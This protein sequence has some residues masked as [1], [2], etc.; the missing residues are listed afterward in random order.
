MLVEFPSVAE[1]V[2]L[3][4]RDPA[5]HGAGATRDVPRGALDPVPHRHQPRRR[6]RRGR[7]HLRRRRQRRRAAGDAGRAGRH[8]RL[9]GGPRPGRR[10]ARGRAS[11]TWASSTVKNIARPIR[12]FRVAARRQARAGATAA[13]G[14]R[15]PQRRADKPSIAVL[16]FVNMSGD[17]EQEFFAD[18]LT[19]DIIT[20]LSRFRELLV[21]SRNSAFVHKGKPVKVQEVA[22][23][24]GVEYV[25]E[26]S[27]RKAGRPGAGHRPADR[28]RDRPPRLGRALRPRAR[29]HLR[30]PGRGDRRDRRHPA[31]PRR[32]GDATT[33]PSA[34]RPTAWRPTSACWPARCCTIARTARTTPRRCACS[35][36]RIA[37]DPDYAHAHA[38][39]ACVLGQTWVNGWCEDRDADLEPRGRGAADGARR[40]TTTTATCTASSRRVNLTPTTTTRRST[41]RSAALALNPNN[42][43]IVVQQGELLDLARPA[44]GRDR[45]DPQGDAPQPLPSRALLEPSRPRLLRRPP[46]RR[47]DRG[48]PADHPAAMPAITRFS[49]PP[50]R[51]WATPRRRA[52]TPPRS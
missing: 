39:K 31:R 33:A 6:H 25:V 38:W 7:R 32:G 8:L 2:Q 29:G 20:E 36:A 3:R 9:G 49:R 27:V 48:L 51:S 44:G 10:P 46:L 24:L 23:E 40:S 34:S 21:I 37:L 28:R 47:G 41:T 35:I 26:G 22:R 17:P 42:D 19:E 18:G 16:P 15:A 4:R 13:A 50:T 5:A 43:L 1:A 52:P 11:R 30:H 45:V 12:V 14:R